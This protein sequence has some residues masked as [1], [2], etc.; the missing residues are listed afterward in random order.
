V[1]GTASRRLEERESEVRRRVGTQGVGVGD[2]LRGL[3]GVLGEQ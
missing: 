2:V 3:A 1:L